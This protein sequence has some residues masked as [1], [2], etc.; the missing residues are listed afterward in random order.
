MQRW[1]VATPL[2]LLFMAVAVG[3]PSSCSRDGRDSEGTREGGPPRADLILFGDFHSHSNNSMDA[4]A[5][6]IP[7]VGGT[8]SRPPELSC[9]F[10]RACAGLDFWA[11]T[12]HAEEQGPTQWR[13]NV[14]AVR[15][16]E[17][18]Y[19][20]EEAD[21][22]LISFLGWEW[23]FNST[24]ADSNYGH[25]NI[26]LKGL[27]EHEV[28]PR[29][30]A[31]PGGFAAF[32]LRSIDLF[33]LLAVAL[34]GEHRA[35]YSRVRD[36]VKS[37]LAT[38][39]CDPGLDT[40]EL[41]EE[42]HEV[43]PDL[44]SLY[45]KFDRWGIE[46][47]VVPHGMTWG[48]NRPLNASWQHLA[49]VQYDPRY[50]PVAEIFSGHG[51]AEEYRSWQHAL[52]S[53]SGALS[54]PE[55]TDEFEPCCRRAGEILRARSPACT[56]DPRGEV[57]EADI[58]RAQQEFLDAGS[59]GIKTIP[60]AGPQEWLDCGQCRDCF[61]PPLDHRPAASIQAA[62]TVPGEEG[63][64]PGD[65]WRYGFGFIGSTD[66]HRAGPGAGYK[67]FR[68][69]SDGYGPARPEWG[70]IVGLVGSMVTPDYGRQNSF[71]YTGGL[72]AV[73]TRDKSR[74]A[75]W[76]AVQAR[77]VYATS[78]ERILLWFDL[79]NGPGGTQLPMG[80]RATIAEAPVFRV[81]ALGAFKQ[82]DGCPEWVRSERSQSFIDEVCFG[83]CY[84]PTTERYAIA[85]I[86][87]IKV[88]LRASSAEPTEAL[89]E[90]P[91]LSVPCP[92]SGATGC[93]VTFSDPEFTSKG[94]AAAYYVRVLQEP[95]RQFNAG[96][97]RCVLDEEGNCLETAPCDNGAG[98]AGD[99][100]LA[101]ASERA[102]S[103]PIFLSVSTAGP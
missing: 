4:L 90:D 8:A 49:G 19:G 46:A 83:Q 97:L 14:A 23:S 94:R 47:L 103:S 54:C 73:H 88:L 79:L 57:C 33:Y 53:G 87:V 2:L 29:P 43:A 45:A 36:R 102:W 6:D 18:R 81:R 26:V 98:G 70:W 85:R 38:E 39:P 65:R 56:L 60:G 12:D 72:V 51:S 59:Q 100:C 3:M 77:R 48:A 25:H 27:A 99:E 74:E 89:I 76:E 58:R 55:S 31:A 93:T 28:P 40:L 96:N 62:L 37:F 44:S 69:L 24:S 35:I 78:G 42:C 52:D 64:G 95:T 7:L 75:I 61:E 13:E 11:L 86:E 82:A 32:D 41:P 30:F 66:S 80:S 92:A 22:R 9:E 101:S 71:F 1:G 91:F 34:D 20:G 17:A 21:H 84:N 67:E 16:C 10:A 15:E 5:L 63:Q 50:S 68:R